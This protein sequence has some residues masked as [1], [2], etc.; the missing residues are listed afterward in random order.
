[1]KFDVLGR[2]ENMDLPDGKTAILYSIYE[3]VSNSLHAIAD[4]FGE[5]EAS[6]KGWIRVS[7]TQDNSGEISQIEVRDNGIGFNQLNRS[8]FE[9]SDTRNKY[10]RGGKG[11]GRLIWIKTFET[12]QI[13]SGYEDVDGSRKRVKFNFCPTIDDSIQGLKTRAMKAQEDFGSIVR[14][15]D[16]RKPIGSRLNHAT[17]MKDL[18]LHF[19]PQYIDKSLPSIVVE[20]L[21]YEQSLD[22]FIADRV[23]EPIS[24]SFSFEADGEEWSLTIDHILVDPT[25]STELRNSYILT[26]HGRIVGEPVSVEKKYDLTTLPDRKAYVAMI[27]GVP[28]DQRVDQQRMNFR[29]NRD[30]REALESAILDAIEAHLAEHIKRVRGRQKEIVIEVI[31]EHPQLGSQIGDI[32]EYVKNLYPGMSEEQIANNLF[33]LLFREERKVRKRLE[34][35][36]QETDETSSNDDELSKNVREVLSDLEEQEKLRLAELTA[37][38]HQVLVAANLLLKFDSKSEKYPYERLV[39]DLVCPMGKMYG[40]GSYDDHNLW[41]IDDSLAGYEL[42]ASDKSMASFVR[43]AGSTKE[44]DIVFFNPLGFRR[45]NTNEPVCIVEFKRPGDGSVSGNP[46]DQVLKYIEEL[47]DSTVVGIEGDV[48]TEINKQ[49]PFKCYVICELT[50]ETKSVLRRGIA[51]NE[52]PDGNA[53]YGYSPTHNAMVHVLSF[54]H[55]IDQAYARNREY[56]SALKLPNPSRE[57]RKRAARRRERD[58]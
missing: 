13:E 15:S 4:R 55:M 12:I 25:I 23:N 18:A 52:T 42:F 56:F 3:A 5:I 40:A 49:T 29:F 30:Q 2:I 35:I 41:I 33:T 32:D 47:Q 51:H 45:S 6:E 36:V 58:E 50:E 10:H 20:H 34:K 38:R 19:F 1:M 43:D 28:L 8:A 39:H 9:T 31:A 53:M 11:V 17:L 57:A 44:P 27:R 37:K 48:V 24:E 14:L 54:R 26:A 22:E 46:V 16:L 21:G 7:I